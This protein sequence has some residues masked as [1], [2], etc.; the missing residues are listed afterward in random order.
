MT[1][2]QALDEEIQKDPH[3]LSVLS[4]D[5]PLPDTIM[6]PLYGTDIRNL[7]GHIQEFRDIFDSVQSFDA[8]RARLKKFET[9]M[10]SLDHIVQALS[11]FMLLTLLLMILLI[12]VMVR[13]HAHFFHLERVIARLVGAHPFS[14]WMPY[15]LSVIWYSSIG[16]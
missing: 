5:N 9:S 12:V 3:I 4:G 7:W 10:T 14:I 13:Y 2:Q 11:L 1:K 8:L 6:I 16:F 15:V